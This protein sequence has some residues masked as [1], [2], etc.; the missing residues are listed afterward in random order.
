M[1]I[2]MDNFIIHKMSKTTYCLRIVTKYLDMKNIKY[3]YCT[4]GHV[5]KLYES[6]C[7]IQ[8]NDKYRLSIQTH[9]DLV[10][11][12]FAETALLDGKEIV[13]GQ[14]GYGHDVMRHDSPEKL[15]EHIENMVN[16]RRPLHIVRRPLQHQ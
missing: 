2:F 3:S 6:G 12:D 9:N 4:G 13:Y 8:L 11:S 10:G 1:D 7:Q 5:F 16:I 14:Y 15:F